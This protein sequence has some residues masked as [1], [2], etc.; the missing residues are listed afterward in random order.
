MSL[1]ALVAV[2]ISILFIMANWFLEHQFNAEADRLLALPRA[3][4]NSADG[5]NQALTLL[6]NAAQIQQ[7]WTPTA[8]ILLQLL[9]TAPAGIQLTSLTYSKQLNSV[10][11]Q[12]V[13]SQ[14]DS[15]LDFTKNLES[16]PIVTTVNL[17]IETLTK[18]TEIP[19]SI[20]V[21]ITIPDQL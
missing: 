13:A 14:R 19:F 9:S 17:P 5:L 18:Q 7:R 3:A 11:I 21:A 20:I 15:I 10:H 12:G 1:L 2:M 16:N 6:S 4:N 8:P